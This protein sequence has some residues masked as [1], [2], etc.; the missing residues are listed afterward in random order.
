MCC[1]ALFVER[2]CDVLYVFMCLYV[3]VG[4]VCVCLCFVCLNDI[5]FVVV[6]ALFD[7]VFDAVGRLCVF[8]FVLRSCKFVVLVLMCVR[9][10]VLSC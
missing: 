1:F 7:V 10:Y 4:C 9:L 8:C 6:L 3:C 5:V 2:C